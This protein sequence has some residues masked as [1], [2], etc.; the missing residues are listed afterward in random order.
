MRKFLVSDYDGTFHTDDESI[1]NNIEK[2]KTFRN[3]GNIFAIATGRSFYDF[4][5]LLDKFDI[6]YDYLIIN[7]GA[8]LLDKNHNIISNYSISNIAKENIKNKF[9]LV[10]DNHI[11]VCKCLE[12]RTS[13]LQNDITKI[14][15]KCN[16]K[17][18]QISFN[19]TL[20]SNYGDFI[21]SYL[22]TGLNNS[23]EIISCNTNKSTAIQEIAKIENIGKENIYTVGDSFNDLEML[24]SFNGFCMESGEELVKSNII[25]KCKSVVEIID[26][27]IGGNNE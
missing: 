19:D 13:I 15:I 24:N 16:S 18:E 22:I 7:H 5:K 3:N 14:H 8:T 17:E 25:N 23:I 21:K 4:T 11:F 10:D 20:N 27:I 2:V 1:K 26:K 6:E 9:G 12:S